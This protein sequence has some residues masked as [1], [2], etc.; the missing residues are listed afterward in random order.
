MNAGNSRVS[1]SVGRSL[2]TMLTSYIDIIFY[3]M[4]SKHH[5]ICTFM[6]EL[7]YFL[8]KSGLNKELSLLK[9]FNW[10]VT[11]AAIIDF[12]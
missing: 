8:K 9:Y 6:I 10:K 4:R 7:A 1:H 11:A 5:I 12:F 2:T 3:N